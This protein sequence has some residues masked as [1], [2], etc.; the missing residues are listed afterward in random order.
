MFHSE[1]DALEESDVHER[2]V[3][4]IEIVSG[5]LQLIQLTSCDETDGCEIFIGLFDCS[6]KSV[7]DGFDSIVDPFDL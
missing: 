5:R 3:E 7:T 1:K 4:T 6:A 2:W